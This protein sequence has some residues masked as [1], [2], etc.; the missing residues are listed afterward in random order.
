ME[1]N[2][3]QNMPV[4]FP[5]DEVFVQ[6]FKG[7]PLQDMAW[8][9]YVSAGNRDRVSQFLRDGKLTGSGLF[10]RDTYESI[11]QLVLS[12]QNI[13]QKYLFIEPPNLCSF[14]DTL[15]QY[16]NWLQDMDNGPLSTI[17]GSQRKMFEHFT[18]SQSSAAGTFVEALFKAFKTQFRTVFE[19]KRESPKTHFESFHDAYEFFLRDIKKDQA[20]KGGYEPNTTA[21]LMGF[22]WG[23]SEPGSVNNNAVIPL[24][25][26]KICSC[27]TWFFTSNKM[28]ILLDNFDTNLSRFKGTVHDISFFVKQLARPNER[29]NMPQDILNQSSFFQ[30]QEFIKMLVKNPR[31]QPTYEY[32]K[33]LKQ[34]LVVLFAMAGHEYPTTMGVALMK[35]SGELR[36]SGEPKLLQILYQLNQTFLAKMC[37][38]TDAKMN[39]PNLDFIMDFASPEKGQPLMAAWQESATNTLPEQVWLSEM[40]VQKEHGPQRADGQSGGKLL[41]LAG[42]ICLI[43]LFAYL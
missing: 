27:V 38:D 19:S 28:E 35:Y 5:L 13:V 37:F 1:H 9:Y 7:H 8:L 26:N 16:C 25:L 6:T 4:D 10:E 31:D 30:K 43:Y 20:W 11:P 14:I 34:N 12:L 42:S 32:Y 40:A 36:K 33:L 18:E 17:P 15:F 29:L 2:S 22:E 24:M 3:K 39:R 41:Y 21:N 23:K